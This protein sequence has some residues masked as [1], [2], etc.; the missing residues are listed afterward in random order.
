MIE[1]PVK[2]VH[3]QAPT[4]ALIDD[5]DFEA[6]R[7]FVWTAS[8]RVHKDNKWLY[9]CS[10]VPSFGYTVAMHRLILPAPKGMITD[11]IN[12]DRF[13]NRRQNLRICTKAENM[14]N[15]QKGV[16]TKCKYKGVHKHGRKYLASICANSIQKVIGSF[17]SELDAALAYDRAAIEL[18]GEFARLNFPLEK[19]LSVN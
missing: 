10:H 16:R 15:R 4:V 17:D 11:H 12:G 14:R 18:H 6:V 5:E 2:S 13:D 8:G 3:T 1:I 9:P 19:K 7:K